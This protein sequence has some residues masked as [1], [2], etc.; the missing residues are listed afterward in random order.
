MKR[1]RL[2]ITNNAP[3]V[4]GFALLCLAALILNQFTGGRSNRLLFM[5][6]HSSLKDP[7]TYVRFFTHVLGHSSWTHFIGN[8]SYIPF[9]RKHVLYS[10]S[11]AGA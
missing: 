11:R 6:Y 3:A 1:Q 9:Y 10:A 7:L 8:M 2:I 4:L 5:T